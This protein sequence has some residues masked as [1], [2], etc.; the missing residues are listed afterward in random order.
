MIKSS[1]LLSETCVAADAIVPPPQIKWEY[2][3]AK[4]GPF[5]VH[6]FCLK[7]LKQRLT[8]KLKPNLAAN[9]V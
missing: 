1:V 2:K 3:K 8:I 6:I 7:W 9:L 5:L 4:C